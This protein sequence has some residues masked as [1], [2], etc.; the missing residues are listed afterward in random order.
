MEEPKW[1][2]QR[3]MHEV[4]RR[5]QES[6][7]EVAKAVD[8]LG[9]KG[10]HE[11]ATAV[12]QLADKGAHA[13]AALTEAHQRVMIEF[14]GLSMEMVQES[15]R[16]FR[17]LQ[18]STIDMMRESQ[19]AALRCQMVW[20]QVFTD[21]ARWYQTVWQEGME[22]ARKAFGVVNGTSETV[23][24]SVGRLQ[25]STQQAGAKIELA[26]STAASRMNEVT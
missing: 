22:G 4:P 23:I 12:D 6:M 10:A 25:A 5:M 20:P 15:A 19:A 9:D 8:R 18:H 7:K 21:P 2:E 14:I 17:H 3:K 26:L 11:V 1:Q 16:L 24:D 13:S